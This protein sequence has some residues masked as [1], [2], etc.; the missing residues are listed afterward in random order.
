MTGFRL[1][2]CPDVLSGTHRLGGGR[3]SQC[4]WHLHEQNQGN[5]SEAK[6]RTKPPNHP[7]PPERLTEGRETRRANR[8]R[9]SPGTA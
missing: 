2:T 5:L 3:S 9:R 4:G 6:W 7:H 1:L 8:D